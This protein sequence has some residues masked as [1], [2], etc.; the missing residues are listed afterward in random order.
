MKLK[1]NYEGTTYYN[2]AT[3]ALFW[4]YIYIVL[5]CRDSRC[6]GN[7]PAG[8]RSKEEGNKHCAAI[9]EWLQRESE[10]AAMLQQ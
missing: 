4:G 1:R 8:C 2:G 5:I 3:T 7:R 10:L 9:L 6:D